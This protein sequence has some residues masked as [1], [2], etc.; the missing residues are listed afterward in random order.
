MK[1]KTI[2]IYISAVIFSLPIFAQQKTSVIQTEEE[3][4]SLMPVTGTVETF[5]GDY[6]L[7][8]SF[9]AVGEGDKIFKLM[10]HQRASQLYLWGLPIVAM[11]TWIEGNREVYGC[12][13]N[14]LLSVK[15]FNERRG[16][17]TANET[18]DYYF[19][20]SNTKDGAVIVEI[21]E[22]LAVGLVDDMWQQGITDLG[23]FGPNS[24]NGGTHVFI[25]PNTPPELIPETKDGQILHKV[26]TN[27]VFY[28]LRLLGAPD[29]V[30]KLIG[31]VEIYNYG[32]KKPKK[33]IQGN[34]KFLANYQQRGLDFWKVLHMA[35]NNEEVQ[36]RDRFFMYWLRNLGI[37]K[38]KPFNPSP[39]QIE[40]LEDGAK[41]GELMAKTLVYDERLEGVLRQNNWRMILGGEWGDG[42]KNTQRMKHYDTFDPRA[43]Y[44]YEAVTTSPAMTIPTPGKAQ[45]YIGKFEDEEGNRLQG[46]NNY[47]IKINGP[48]PA[49]LFWSTVIY[50]TDTRCLIDNRKGA[51]GGKATVGSK[52]EGLRI[53]EDGSY[54][55]LLGPGD[56]PKGWEANYVQTLSGRGWFPYMR[57]YGAQKD[58]FNDAYKFPTINKV[59][60]FSKLD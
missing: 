32:S 56:P 31:K 42:I 48:V 55:M 2:L 46:G 35:I 58:F 51:H 43:R 29:Q 44:N 4:Q 14:D 9:P 11:T 16:L 5:F 23:L 36:D 40:I 53:N 1:N 26:N 12:G 28:L 15:T 3:F 49:E 6:E 59:K 19:G 20:A 54:T 45:A 38:G 50:D 57:A 13:Y 33:V 18:T 22:G 25:G 10:D 8:H 24:G 47:I 21:P 60:D 30:Q 52:T 27:Q 41:V 17:L 39:E 37:E 7:D 34:D